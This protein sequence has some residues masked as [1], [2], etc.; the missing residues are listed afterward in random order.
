MSAQPTATLALLIDGDN[1][2]S[3][4][5]A[6][7]F[8][9]IAEYGTA[10]VRRIYGD[11]STPYLNG[12]KECLAKHS[13]QP[14]QQFANSG[15][16][17]TDIAMVIDAMDLLHAGRFSGFCIVSSDRDFTRLATR[18]REQGVSV[19]G[20][21]ERK[22]PDSFFNACDRFMYF[23]EHTI[24]DEISQVPPPAPAGE[25]KA[26]RFAGNSA[27]LALLRMAIAAVGDDSGW[28]RMSRIG[29]Y[30]K[31]TDKDFKTKYGPLQKL[32][33]S[34]GIADVDRT[35]YGRIVSVL[36]NSGSRKAA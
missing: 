17:S 31:V 18:I 27:A 33:V 4:C 29:Q 14:I 26:A 13:I 12:W 15:K 25:T 3:Q 1:V 30:L 24:H 8:D 19:Y 35:E 22:T 34:S 6:K 2:T 32:I 23:D 9:K 28:A 36:L 5:V 16:N 7:I 10:T 21:G 20:F 11:W